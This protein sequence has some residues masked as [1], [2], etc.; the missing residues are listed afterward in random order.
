MLKKIYY[1][2]HRLSSKSQEREEYSSGYWQDAVRTEVLFLCRALAGRALE[3]GC[4]EGLFLIPLAKQHQRLEVWGVDN[5]NTRLNR[6]KEKSRQDNLTNVHLLLQGASDLAFQDEY[7]DAVICVN[8]FFNMES[9]ET[10]RKT[11]TQMNRVCKKEGRIIFDF[12]NSLNP[13]LRFKYRFARY[14]DATVKDLPLNTYY[15]REIE[16][17]L[18]DLNLAVVNRKSIGL[19]VARFAPITIIE[20]KKIC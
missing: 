15:P 11:L 7:F 12:R 19:A 14:Y 4:G 10:V 13:L 5:N 8:V 9:I 3:V 20:A 18:Q 6:A 17:I 1:W 16:S 2:L